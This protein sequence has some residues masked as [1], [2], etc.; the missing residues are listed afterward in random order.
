[1]FEN[2]FNFELISRVIS[3]KNSFK[4]LY[5]FLKEKNFKRILLVLDRNLYNNS[6]YTQNYAFGLK[7]KKL[8]KKKIFFSGS[9]EP[10]YQL[11]NQT[12]KKIKS[13]KEYFYDSIISIGGGS[14]IDFAKGI[15]TLLTNP[16]NSLKYKG[17]PKKLNPSLP[18]IAIPSTT[19]TGSEL[20]YNAVFTDLKTN[21]KLGINTKNNY[22][23]LSILDPKILINSPIKVILCSSLGALI[24]SVD[25]LFNKKSTKISEI[26]SEKS[27]KLIINN[28]PK[29]LKNKK[30]LECWSQMQWGAYFSVAALLNSGS[31]PAGKISYYLSTNHNIPQGMGYAISGL[32]FFKKNHEKGFYKYS[33]LYN[34]IDKKN[35]NK[36]LSNKGKSAYV[37]NN[38]FEIFNKNKHFMQKINIEH[39]AVKKIMNSMPITIADNN[40]IKLNQK[41][42]EEVVKNIVTAN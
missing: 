29:I 20:A 37:L 8:I 25:T 41:E 18:I 34:L 3:G 26:F 40:P 7:K 30:D 35:N 17:F 14:T 5:N 33:K 39:H 15:A 12:V 27:F 42:L 24:R 36:K 23:L 38:L 6:C 2:N 32:Y 16:G 21:T 22:P 28:L 4:P 19:G 1:M 10:T 13:R 31:G 9:N 11:L